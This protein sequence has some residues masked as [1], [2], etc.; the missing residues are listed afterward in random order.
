[1]E[2]AK[3][4]LIPALLYYRAVGFMVHMEAKRLGLWRYSQTPAAR[5]VRAAQDI[6]LLIPFS[7]SS[8]LDKGTIRRRVDI[9][10]F[11]RP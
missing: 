6:Y 8:L 4:A 2:I 7:Y 1:M 3:A 10:A 9:A 5:L 11:W